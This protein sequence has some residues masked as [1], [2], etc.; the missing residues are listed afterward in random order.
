MKYERAADNLVS[1]V[2]QSRCRNQSIYYEN[3]CTWRVF[4]A[5]KRGLFSTFKIDEILLS[6]CTV[7]CHAIMADRYPRMLSSKLPADC[8]FV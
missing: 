6:T 8:P 7:L 4:K 3:A 1:E 2:T 5:P